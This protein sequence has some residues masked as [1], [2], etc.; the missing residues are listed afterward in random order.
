MFKAVSNL[1]KKTRILE[2]LKKR[3]D[4]PTNEQP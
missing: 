4:L 3:T 1:L 2:I